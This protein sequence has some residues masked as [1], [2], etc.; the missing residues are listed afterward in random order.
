MKI[1]TQVYVITKTDILHLGSFSLVWRAVLK[2]KGL[3]MI[4]SQKSEI[5]LLSNR[6]KVNPK[7]A[8][9]VSV[10]E[11]ILRTEVGSMPC[12]RRL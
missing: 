7:L 11:A 1:Q 3:T 12:N 8:I 6:Y 10:L 5:L 2:G 9:L 4:S